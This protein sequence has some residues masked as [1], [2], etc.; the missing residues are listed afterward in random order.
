LFALSVALIAVLSYYGYRA[1]MAGVHDIS[2]KFEDE[3]TAWQRL[4]R[5]WKAPPD[6][7]SNDQVFPTKFGDYTRSYVDNKTTVEALNLTLAGRHAHYKGR[8]W[9]VD[10]NAYFPMP[11]PEK[12][13]L[14]ERLIDLIGKQDRFGESLTEEQA[15]MRNSPMGSKLIYR[16]D[17]LNVTAGARHRGCMW[18]KDG[19]LF[20]LRSDTI[21]DPEAI[22]HKFLDANNAK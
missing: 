13:T 14:Y 6:G 22:L 2:S 21:D 18:W 19:W 8:M 5:E 15:R 7:A 11:Q 20:L 16:I 9:D 12:E 4:D 1:I 10:V 3:P 17:G